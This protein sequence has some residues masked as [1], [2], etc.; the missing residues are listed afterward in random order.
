MRNESEKVDSGVP[1]NTFDQLVDALRLRFQP[2]HDKLTATLQVMAMK[3]V[4]GESIQ[5]Y[6]NRFQALAGKAQL[7]ETT[8]CTCFVGGL[9]D[10]RLQHDLYQPMQDGI[11]QPL[12]QRATFCDKGENPF[13][14]VNNRST[15]YDADHTPKMTAKQRRQEFYRKLKEARKS[16]LPRNK[17]FRPDRRSQPFRNGDGNGNGN[18]NGNAKPKG[19]GKGNCFK[20]GKAGHFAY[21]CRST[22]GVNAHTSLSDFQRR[23]HELETEQKYTHAYMAHCGVALPAQMSQQP[24]QPSFPASFPAPGTAHQVRFAQQHRSS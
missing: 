14:K 7:P 11:L 4:Q 6:I 3:Q 18:G 24:A 15:R 5:E 8:L 9:I 23:I 1:Y 21:E 16:G 10:E 12:Y 17:N 22:R 20:C 19:N 13:S 2:K